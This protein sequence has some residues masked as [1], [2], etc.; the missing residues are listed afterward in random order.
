MGALPPPPLGDP[1]ADIP[2]GWNE[3]PGARGCS[4]EARNFR[5]NLS[6]LRAEGVDRVLAL[7]SDRAAYQQ[8]LVDRLH[9]PYPILSD[10][11]L[12]LADDLKLPTFDA[13]GQR[14]HRR[15]TLVLRGT[16]VEPA[17]YPV[18]PVTF[19]VAPQWGLRP[20]GPA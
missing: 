1:A 14:L 2:E 5:D 18:P 9:L 7:S 3:I 6:A 4:Q 8:A 19:F 10:P 15:L 17:F 11:R 16:T 12:T 20:S 13:R